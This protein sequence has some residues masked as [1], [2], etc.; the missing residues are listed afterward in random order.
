[1]S[2]DLEEQKGWS[3]E[4]DMEGMSQVVGTGYQK[5]RMVIKV[6]DI[7]VPAEYW[8]AYHGR[9]VRRKKEDKDLIA[10]LYEKKKL[11]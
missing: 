6:A 3:R 10:W 5:I 2:T 8:M 1:M 11:C 9:E 7:G 4:I